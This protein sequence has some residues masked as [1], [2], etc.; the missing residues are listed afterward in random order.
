MVDMFPVVQYFWNNLNVGCGVR[1]GGFKIDESLKDTL[2]VIGF[3]TAASVTAKWGLKRERDH[4]C[5]SSPNH[6]QSTSNVH[7]QY[8]EMAYWRNAGTG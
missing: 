6:F 4:Q 2:S 5:T 7:Q 1:G 8:R 3:S